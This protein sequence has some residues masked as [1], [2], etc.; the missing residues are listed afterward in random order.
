MMTMFK[1][2]KL[3]EWYSEHLC[4]CVSRSV[5]SDSLQPHELQPARLL[6]P[7]NSQGKNTWVGCHSLLQG[8]FPCQFSFTI[9]N[10]LGL[11]FHT[12]TQILNPLFIHWSIFPF[13]YNCRQQFA[14]LLNAL[15]Y[16]SLTGVQCLFMQNCILHQRY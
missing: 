11:L 16:I 6:C 5:M 12:S 4:K 7:W 3:K 15:S 13:Q 10:F 14:P 8:I 1:Q 9:N 2:K